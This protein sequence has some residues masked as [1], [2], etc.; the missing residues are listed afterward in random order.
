VYDV[1]NLHNPATTPKKDHG[2]SLGSWS[3]T[4]TRPLHIPPSFQAFAP[5]RHNYKEAN[6]YRKSKQKT[7]NTHYPRIPSHTF[8]QG[9]HRTPFPKDTIAHLPSTIPSHAFHR[10]R[11]PSHVGRCRRAWR[12]CAGQGVNVLHVRP[13]FIDDLDFVHVRHESHAH[14]VRTATVYRSG[15]RVEDAVY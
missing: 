5:G 15:G 4:R 14:L 2:L 12:W 6:G 11:S 7:G 9:Y 3:V 10:P 1:S 13:R 8:P